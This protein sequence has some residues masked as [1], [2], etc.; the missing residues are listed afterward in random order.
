[1]V[2]DAR[3]RYG[4][5]KEIGLRLQVLCHETAI[6][7]A[8]ASNL[9]GIDERMAG[10]EFLRSFNDIFSHSLPRC[11]DMTGRKLLSKSHG[12]TGLNDQHDVSQCGI[13]M[14]RITCFKVAARWRASS[15]IINDERIMLR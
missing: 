1:M 14:V 9:L 6:R 8:D 10:H 13:G 15:I 2:A 3:M 7:C 4:S 12:T 11:V 5:R